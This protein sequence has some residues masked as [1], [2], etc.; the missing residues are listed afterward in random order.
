MRRA[1]LALAI[2]A[3]SA[4]AR[5]G[6]P[7][8]NA[9]KTASPS[10]IKI[11]IA[12]GPGEGEGVERAQAEV[13]HALAETVRSLASLEL[14]AGKRGSPSS[15]EA[16]PF[17]RAQAVGREQ[18]AE[19]ALAVDVAP[20][21]DGLVVYLHLVETS[22]GRELGAGTITLAES[23]VPLAAGDRT[24][25]RGGAVRVLA[26]ERYTGRVKLHVDVAGAQVVL[27]GQPLKSQTQAA[28]QTLELVVGTHALRVTHPAYHDFLR[29]IDVEFDKTFELDVALSAYPLSEGQMTERRQQVILVP[30]PQDPTRPPRRWRWWLLG[31]GIAVVAA[32]TIGLVYALRP[33]VHQDLVIDYR[34]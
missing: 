18:A 28:D 6:N 10:A 27:D 3:G 26:P 14:T 31:G 9:N 23:H 13:V 22:S 7:P 29:F 17:A 33:S 30:A 15:R 12:P 32:G 19:R 5:A 25:L 21:G 34:H 2:V 24:R 16:D 4:S 20:L 11:A 8:P 1:L